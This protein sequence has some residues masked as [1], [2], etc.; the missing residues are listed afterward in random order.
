[1]LHFE[2]STSASAARSKRTLSTEMRRRTIADSTVR[3]S[4]TTSALSNSHPDSPDF[5]SELGSNIQVYVRCRSRN[6]REIEEKSSVVISTMGAQGK[7]VVLSDPSSVLSHTKKTYIFDQVF[8]VESDQEVVFNATAQNYIHEMLQGYNCTIFA[9]GQTGTGKTYTMSGDINILGDLESQDKILLGEHAGIIPRV[10]VNLFQYLTRE[11]TEYSVKISF[12]ELYNERLK[13]LLSQSKETEES[14]RIFDNHIPSGNSKIQKSSRNNTYSSIM[15]KGMEEIYIKSAHEGLQLLTEGSLKRKVASTKC[16]DLSSRS[17]TIFTITTNITK[18]DPVSGEQYVKIGKLNLVDLAGSENISRSG[19]ENMRAQE[20]GLINKSLLTLGRVIN[21]LVDHSQHIPY[22][23]SKLTR[24]LQDSLGGKTKTCIIATVSPAKISMEETISTLEY[25]TRAKSIKNTPQINQSMSKDVCINEYVQEIER[26]RQELKASRQKDGVYITQ[27]QFDLYESNGI[28]VDEQKAKIVNMEEQIKKF[29]EKYVNQTAINKELE[30]SLKNSQE[31]SNDLLD[32]QASLISIFGEYQSNFKLFETEINTIHE[33][34]LNLIDLISTERNDLQLSSQKYYD[35]LVETFRT[36]E[37]QMKFILQSQT[38]L[39]SYNIKFKEVIGGVFE[40]LEDNTINFRKKILTETQELDFS[41]TILS[42]EE[43]DNCLQE[44]IRVLTTPQKEQMEKIYSSHTDIIKGL[45]KS[46]IG[47]SDDIRH[48]MEQFLQDLNLKTNDALVLAKTQYLKKIE[49]LKTLVDTQKE[50]ILSLE[51]KLTE[52]REKSIKTDEKIFE[53]EQYFKN[54]VEKEKE[55]VFDSISIAIL[56]AKKKHDQIDSGVLSKCS[57]II[58]DTLTQINNVND[59]SLKSLAQ[60][61]VNSSK[62]LITQFQDVA[63]TIDKTSKTTALQLDQ[64]IQDVPISKSFTLFKQKL[65]KS[66]GEE[67]SKT[68]LEILE[69]FEQGQRESQLAISNC[70]SIQLSKLK[71][72]IKE[73]TNITHTRLEAIK[74]STEDLCKYILQGC[75]DN[76]NQISTTQTDI[77]QD[78][79]NGLT[80]IMNALKPYLDKSATLHDCPET[81]VDA[82]ASRMV[83]LPKFK[84]PH[85]YSIYED[86][87]LSSRVENSTSEVNDAIPLENRSPSHATYPAIRFNPSTP[88]PVPD[89][90]LPKVLIPRS[91]NSTAKRIHS[92][93]PPLKYNFNKTPNTTNNLK[94]RFTFEG[95]AN[96]MSKDDE[97][98]R[99]S[100]EMGDEK[101]AKKTRFETESPTKVD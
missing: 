35:F 38:T 62:A 78:H 7:E 9:Y 87:K 5:E 21:A 46:T 84:K 29:K 67:A 52:E 88:V 26:L 57:S 90:P 72:I 1:M 97:N 34:N 19:A 28:L 99:S 53:L 63:D 17:H 16:N 2:R 20:A 25:A 14:I 3:R 10:L 91:I 30:T 79:T 23:E 94:R 89:Q 81:K 82:I 66:C 64:T 12:L 71:H 85:N 31:L 47:S 93:S 100:N 96:T 95:E 58:S 65:L 101:E 61:S 83:D 60:Q 74:S 41:S 33:N 45:Y 56:S 44:N 73:D 48:S 4:R 6:Q 76:M 11:S 69:E 39:S 75:K 18:I 8:G 40:E 15:V 86:L 13:D 24:L 49:E 51:G 68:L 50:Q 92:F 37:N 77:I 59:M 27:E 43:L 55:S 32:K 80:S 42:I 70:Q 22:R 54:Y 36:I 98:D